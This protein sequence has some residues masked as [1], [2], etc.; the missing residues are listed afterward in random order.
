MFSGCYFTAMTLKKY[1]YKHGVSRCAAAWNVSER[2]VYYWKE[3]RTRP[4]RRVA[5]R[6]MRKSGLTLMG[7]YK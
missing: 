2:T 5:E 6:I 1:I 3:G 4:H 7:I